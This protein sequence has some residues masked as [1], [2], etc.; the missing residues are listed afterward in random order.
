VSR[1]LFACEG[2]ILVVD[3]TQ[4][5]EAQT[6]ANLYLAID[7]DLVIVP[8]LNKIDL[9]SARPDEVA[10]EVTHSLGG[11][12]ED[13]LRVSAKEGVGI[14]DLLEAI[15]QQMPSPR[16]S[17]PAAPDTTSCVLTLLPST[18][19]ASIQTS[20]PFERALFSFNGST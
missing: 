8:V 20:V 16:A 4:G 19:I 5:V 6:L 10:E 9:A 2:A 17:Q 11:K 7:A 18:Y 12:P 3:A 1:A 14:D 15:V 13:V